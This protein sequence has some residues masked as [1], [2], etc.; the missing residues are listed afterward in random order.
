MYRERFGD[1][2]CPTPMKRVFRRIED[3]EQA[4]KEVHDTTMAVYRCPCGGMH[5]GHRRPD[6][7]RVVRVGV[8]DINI[9]PDMD[10]F[11]SDFG[12]DPNSWDGYSW[13]E[14][15]EKI[16]A[17]LETIGGYVPEKL[18]EKYNLIGLRSTVADAKRFLAQVAR[19]C[20]KVPTVV[21]PRDDD[22]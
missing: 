6:T 1:G 3:A 10:T 18:E 7:E 4:I 13:T 16:E 21:V 19:E 11:F 22:Y 20:R 9:P 17:A 15:N 2:Y 5:I 12:A 8:I 14:V